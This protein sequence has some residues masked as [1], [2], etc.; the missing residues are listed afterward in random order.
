MIFEKR[1]YLDGN[2]Y[3]PAKQAPQFDYRSRIHRYGDGFFETMKFFRGNIRHAHLHAERIRKSLLLL[4]MP[5]TDVSTDEIFQLIEDQIR[6][7]HWSA[8][9]IRLSYYRESDGFYTPENARLLY[10]IEIQ[11]LEQEGYPLN[12]K[13]LVVGNYSELTKNENYLSLLKTQSSLLYVM[14]GIHAKENGWDECV[15]F[16]QVGR[17]CEAISGNIFCVVGD[18]ILTPPLNEHCI[19]GVMRKVVL[20]CAKSYG[21]QIFERPISEIE[22]NSSTEIFITNALKGIQWVAN[23]RGKELRNS[24]AKVISTR[25]V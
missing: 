5:S 16:N 7:L 9:R 10:Y 14:A 1:V 12:E 8:A 23:Y 11:A 18:F 4:K 3:N 24:Y 6:D 19:D 25:I 22:L 20:D 2:W 13:G 15:I 17:V 21:Y